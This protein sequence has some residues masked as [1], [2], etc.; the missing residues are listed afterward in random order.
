[1]E[2]TNFYPLIMTYDSETVGRL[3]E[4]LGFEKRH[5]KKNVRGT[6]VPAFA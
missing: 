2:I 6:K 5:E 1:M 3:F 4:E